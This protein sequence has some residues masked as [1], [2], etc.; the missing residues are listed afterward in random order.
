MTE[1]YKFL[2]SCRNFFVL[3][4]NGDFPAGRPFGAVMEYG[5]K[6]YIATHNANQVHKQL[7]QNGNIQLLAQKENTRDW[8]RITGIATECNDIALKKKM[9][10]EC[11]VL[12]KHYISADDEHYLLF[13]VQIIKSEFH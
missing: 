2:K 7:R 9:R 11:S 10:E 13:A 5:G 6:L 3:T 8:L 12:Q 4:L 1:E